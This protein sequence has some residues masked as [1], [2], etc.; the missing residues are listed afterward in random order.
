MV[1]KGEWAETRLKNLSDTDRLRDES[2]V[3]SGFGKNVS[4]WLTREYVY[5]TNVLH[6]A[7]E[8]SNRGH[9][10]AF[11]KSLPTW[12]I[13]LFSNE[14]DIVLDPFMGSGTTALAAI[15]L[16]RRY[17]GIELS[18]KYF[19]LAE[20]ATRN[21]NKTKRMIMEARN[22]RYRTGKSDIKESPGVSPK[23]IATGANA[24]NEAA[25]KSKKSISV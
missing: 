3:G 18:Q 21:V 5:P 11:P 6:M 13:K 9:S 12:F 16:N 1:P 8:S 4:N 7:T 10:A 19:E 24:Q 17:V 23:E 22:G 20:Q 15:D 14:G 25:P 2:K